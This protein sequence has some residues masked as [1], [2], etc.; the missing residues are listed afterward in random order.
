MLKYRSV[1]SL[2]VALS[3]S[4]I[5]SFEA[6]ASY[7]RDIYTYHNNQY[8]WLENSR[9]KVKQPKYYCAFGVSVP[10]YIDITNRYKG[11]P[12][13]GIA[14]SKPKKKLFYSAAAGMRSSF[15]D[16]VAFEVEA[17]F[18]KSKSKVYGYTEDFVGLSSD[19]ESFSL[20]LNSYYMFEGYGG[21]R[22]FVGAGVGVSYNNLANIVLTPQSGAGSPR[23][24]EDKSKVSPA[25]QVMLGVNKN[26]A[27]NIDVQV[28]VKAMSLG[29]FVGAGSEGKFRSVALSGDIGFK[30]SLDH[31]KKI[32]RKSKRGA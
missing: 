10:T 31:L 19:I 18:Y 22:P 20:L 12:N 16:Q 30:Y 23:E 5:L 1:F 4:S 28:K 26:I 24:F 9:R 17:L 15:D 7:D 13:S 3:L 11:D 2:C 6:Q 8:S 27:K 29:K 32:K 21:F 25:V 14:L